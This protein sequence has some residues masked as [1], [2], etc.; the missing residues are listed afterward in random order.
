MNPD[1]FVEMQDFKESLKPEMQRTFGAPRV[2]EEGKGAP[3]RFDANKLRDLAGGD[4]EKLE[5][6]AEDIAMHMSAK[7]SRDEV[8]VE[9]EVETEGAKHE[10]L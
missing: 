5:R 8:P 6:M 4:T 7:K 2:K 10:E 1:D 3:V 9:A